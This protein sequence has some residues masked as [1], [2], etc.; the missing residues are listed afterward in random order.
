MNSKITT[1]N[2]EMMIVLDGRLDTAA[3]PVLTEE[4]GT[5]PEA[6][7]HITIDLTDLKYIASSGLRV[8]LSLLKQMNA[9]G[10][11]V[12]LKN[13][14]PMVAEVLDSTGFSDIFEIIE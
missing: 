14:N 10:G 9:K 8:L 2:N 6:V 12:T 1:D 3:A 5:I 13:P 4:I 11:S 7:N